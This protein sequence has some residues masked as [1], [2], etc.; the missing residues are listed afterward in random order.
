V[1]L[2][3]SETSESCRLFFWQHELT[4]TIKPLEEKA[5]AA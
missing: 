1:Q 3:D 2:A 5:V 4:V